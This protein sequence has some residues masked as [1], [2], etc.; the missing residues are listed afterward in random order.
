MAETISTTT[1]TIQLPAES[2]IVGVFTPQQV[3]LEQRN[4]KIV[5]YFMTEEGLKLVGV[6]NLFSTLL[7][8]CTSYTASAYFS[9]QSAAMSVKPSEVTHALLESQATTYGWITILFA[10][11]CIVSLCF[12][13]STV[14]TLTKKPK[15]TTDTRA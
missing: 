7:L 11:M 3:Q 15:A 4:S 1:T 13:G 5:F 12:Y 8:A 6:L 10:V 2:P 14:W 9:F